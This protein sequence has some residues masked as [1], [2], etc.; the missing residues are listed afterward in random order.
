[1][2]RRNIIMIALMGIALL[3]SCSKDD[4]DEPSATP[5]PP[6]SPTPTPE[7]QTTEKGI[8]ELHN[9]PT[10]QSAFSRLIE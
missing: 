9:E 10:D 4:G 7:V 3:A 1:M 6:P 8:D 2:K 5:T